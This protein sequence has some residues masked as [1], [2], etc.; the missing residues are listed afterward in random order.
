MSAVRRPTLATLDQN[1][2]TYAGASYSTNNSNS[3]P[4]TSKITPLH[5]TMAPPMQSSHHNSTLSHRSSRQSHIPQRQSIAISNSNTNGSDDYLGGGSSSAARVASTPAAAYRTARKS[6]MGPPINGGNSI[7]AGATGTG[8]GAGAGAG[9]AGAGQAN[10]GFMARSSTAGASVNAT[11]NHRRSMIAGRQ[12]LAPGA[13]QPPATASKPPPNI[14]PRPLRSREYMSEMKNRVHDFA[15][16]T[17]FGHAGYRGVTS[18]DSPTQSIFLGLF[19]HIFNTAIDP[20]YS[21]QVDAKKPEEEVMMILQEY[22]YPSLGDITK[23]LLGSASSSQYWPKTLA[24]LDWMVVLSSFAG[25]V[26]SGPLDREQAHNAHIS[27]LVSDHSQATSALSSASRSISASEREQL[28]KRV[29][30]ASANLRDAEHAQDDGTDA[31]RWF[32]P[33]TWHC[34]ERFWE[35]EDQFPDEVAN[36]EEIFQKKNASIRAEVERLEKEKKSLEGTLEE[37]TSNDSDLTKAQQ[38]ND[39]IRGDIGKFTKYRDEVLLPKVSKLKSTIS[40]LEESRVESEADMAKLQSHH[41]SLSKQVS[42]Q[43]MSSEEFDRL[44]SERTTLMGEKD[45]LENEIKEHENR[46]YELELATSNMH[47]R[48]EE[49]LKVFNPLGTKVGLFPLS[50]KRSDGS[51]GQ[52]LLDEI[53][54]ALGQSTLLHPGLDLKGDLRQKITSLRKS[55]EKSQRRAMEEKVERQEKYDEICERLHSIK[56]EELEIK[57]RLE[58][59]KDSIEDITRL[60]DEETKLSNEDQYQKDRKLTSTQQI[61][62]KQLTEIEARL[63]ELKTHQKSLATTIKDSLEKYK[64]ELCAAVEECVALK[65]RVGESIEEIGLKLGIEFDSDGVGQQPLE[66]VQKEESKGLDDDQ[67]VEM[68]I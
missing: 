7:G 58:V 68:Q 49:K 4:S 39:T 60:T 25:H 51:S 14:D 36:L 42:S 28:V 24:I 35:G 52:E 1:S 19:R 67:D 9:A 22:R 37:L 33:F 62:F 18:L 53:D 59:I 32:Y 15:E 45:R 38:T 26:P 12:S 46:R 56:E 20:S 21:F 3:R 64:D 34:Y 8:A 30:E 2:N 48:L 47:Q 55:V 31:D 40:R 16:R 44:S 17:G 63:I 41:D 61:G 13:F 50:V 5:S 10:I 54:L 66:D 29:E 57:G 6:V 43:E 23:M 11:P 65:A 27:S